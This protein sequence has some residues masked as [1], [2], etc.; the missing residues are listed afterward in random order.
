MRKYSTKIQNGWAFYDWA[1]SVYPLVITSAI[2]PIFYEGLTTVEDN[3]T[4]T[5]FGREFINT[6]LIAYVSS[7]SFLFISMFLPLLSGIADYIGNKKRF[8]QFFCYLGAAST[9][10]LAF[11]TPDNLELSLVAFFMASVGFWS[12]LVFYNA[13]LPEIAPVGMHDK[14]SAKGYSLGYLGSSTLLIICLVMVLSASDKEQAFTY[15]RI[16]FVLTGLWWIGFSQI[17]YRRLPKTPKKGNETNVI[18]KGYNEL[19]HVWKDLKN[20]L[21]LKRYLQAFFVYSMAVQTI[22]IMAVY[23]GAQEIDWPNKEASRGGLIASILLI[24]FIAILG[25]FLLSKFSALFGNI[26]A[27]LLVV[28]LWIC[29]CV[30]ALWVN[31]PTEFYLTAASVGL[32][33]GGIQALSRSTYS[34]LLPKTKDTASYFSFY[35]ISEKIGIVIG[36]FSY[37]FIHQLTG[38]MR[39]SIFALI[40]FFALGFILLLRVPK[41]K[42]I[43]D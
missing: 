25:A 11:F 14:L 24:Q 38:S 2:F 3:N 17:T 4:V 28:F 22:M 43:A 36:T 8:L 7:A 35:D 1:N 13:Y 39:N 29:I 12:S 34:K 23:F 15:M 21:Q 20:N 9:M 16:A 18:F 30:S 10:C 19:R 31:T 32:V 41:S 27:L 33:M 42:I 6:S 5:F 26:K 40:V 37:G